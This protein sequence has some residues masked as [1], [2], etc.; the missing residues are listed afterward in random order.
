MRRLRLLLVSVMLAALTVTGPPAPAA[1]AGPGQ[2][3]APSWYPLRGTTVVGCSWSNGCSSGYHGYAALDLARNPSGSV[4]GD[5]IYAAGAGLATVYSNGSSCGGSG[6]VAKAVQVDHGNNVKSF[7]YHLGGFAISGPT[8][9]DE[10]TVLGYVGNTGWVEPCS[11]NHLH[12]EVRHNGTR[13]SPGQLKACHGNQMVTYPAA[14][15]GSPADWNNVPRWSSIRNDGTGCA[16]GPPPPGPVSAGIDALV[17]GNRVNLRWGSASGATEY[18]VYRDGVQVSATGN[19]SFLDIQVSAG[20]A[21]TY[22]VVA[23][24]GS[25]ASQPV[26]RYVQTTAE[27]ADRAFLSTKD[28]P[29]MC[30]RAG[31]ETTKLLVCNVRK[32]TGWTTRRPPTGATRPTGPGWSTPTARSPTAAGSTTATRRRATV[33]TA[34]PGPPLLHR[35]PTSATTRTGHT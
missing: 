4:A 5:Q 18:R 33:S 15:A 12:F 8:W 6:T 31:D 27:A 34:P 13:V 24:N 23:R 3:S 9:V 11:F 26:T 16:A 21:Y 30:G 14:F 10:N 25:G 7:Y 28:G 32:A 29:A 17:H 19:T 22:T 20:Q 2:Y 1:A 35:R